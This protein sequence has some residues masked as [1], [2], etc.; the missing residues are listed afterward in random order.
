MIM[1]KIKDIAK[2]SPLFKLEQLRM[3]YAGEKTQTRRINLPQNSEP[4]DIW[5]FREPLR[6]KWGLME[7]RYVVDDALCR[8]VVNWP[9]RLVKYAALFMP[10]VAARRFAEVVAIRQEWL[11][12]IDA[13]DVVAEGYHDIRDFRFVWDAT[14]PQGRQWKD[15]PE[16]W[17]ITFKVIEVKNEDY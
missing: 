11:Q 7:T 6:R 12:D 16:V 4:G 5:Y 3:I 2:P 1:K 13:Q 15:N 17:V 8:F 14:N 9:H 10:K